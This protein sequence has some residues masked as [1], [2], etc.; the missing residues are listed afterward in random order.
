MNYTYAQRTSLAFAATAANMRD[1]CVEI[2]AEADVEIAKLKELIGR[3][4]ERCD[5]SDAAGYYTI[6]THYIRDFFSGSEAP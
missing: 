5:E 1:V 4:I 3:I 2:A 6:S